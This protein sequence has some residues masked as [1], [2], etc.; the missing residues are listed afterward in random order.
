MTAKARVF[1]SISCV[2]AVLF[3]IGPRDALSQVEDAS[4]EYSRRGADSCTGCH[5][6]PRILSIFSTSHGEP[7]D[8]RTPFADLQC[9]GCHG[10]GGDHAKRLRLGEK[11]PPITNFGRDVL[12]TPIAKQNDICTNCHSSEP[13]PAWH[14]S[15]H[16]NEGLSCADCHQSHAPADRVLM[17]AEQAEVCYICHA[18]Q[19]AQSF[20]ISNHP[21]RE[22]KMACS[23]CHNAHESTADSLLNKESVNQ[24]CYT[25]HAETRGPFLW[26]HAPV[27]E[28]CGSCHNPHGSNH[29]ALLGR[30]PPQLCQQCHSQSGHPSIGFTSGGLA[31][32]TP[33]AN[34]LGASC[35]NC[36][37]KVHGTNHPS[38][39]VLAR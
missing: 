12:Q 8:P 34:V 10:P 31:G 25:C 28:D 21:M 3:G 29:P 16:D 30:R 36:H 1:L 17:P 19:R 5:G 37:P 20:K 2:A 35:M 14:G 32:G 26:E 7:A 13:S 33:S 24:V 9:E 6:E 38:G 18:M 4:L 23:S 15:A 22:G 27:V 39:A 11:R